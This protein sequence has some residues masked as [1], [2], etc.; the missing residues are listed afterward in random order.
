MAPSAHTSRISVGWLAVK[1][2]QFATPTG[3]SADLGLVKGWVGYQHAIT[4]WIEPMIGDIPLASLTL[5]QVDGIHAALMDAGLSR[6][7]WVQVRTVLKQS[8]DLGVRRGYLSHNPP[9]LPCSRVVL[10]S[11]WSI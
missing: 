1:R 8:L 9:P 5:A 7:S 11:R 3:V 2:A 10:F 6:S 4:K